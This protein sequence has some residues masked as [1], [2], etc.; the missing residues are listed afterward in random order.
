[1]T[2][3]CGMAIALKVCIATPT[4][5]N[6]AEREEETVMNQKI[7]L[8]ITGCYADLYAS[9][10]ALQVAGRTDAQIHVLQMTEDSA[11]RPSTEKKMHPDEISDLMG[12]ITWLAEIE[13]IGISFHIFGTEAEKELIEFLRSN[14]ITCLVAGAHDRSS[15]QEKNEWLRGVQE[16]LGSDALWFQRSFQVLVTLPWDDVP[17]NRVLQQLGY[18]KRQAGGH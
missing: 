8:L 4:E 10:Q 3:I 17:F 11:D 13:R 5:E 7:A 9:M 14:D 15:L 12:L 16:Q 1:M 6:C 2:Y 18:K